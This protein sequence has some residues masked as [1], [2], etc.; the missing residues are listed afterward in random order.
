ML[1]NFITKHKFNLSSLVLILPFV[2]FY[3][4]LTP[5]FP[6]MWDKRAVGQFEVTIMPY[7][8]DQP[9]SHHGV[10][11]KDFMLFFNQ[12]QVQTIRQ[13]Y[14]NIGS[15]AL[16]ISEFHKFHEGILHGSRHGKE[17]HALAPEEITKQDKLWLTIENWQGETFLT[18]WPIPESITQ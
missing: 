4:S 8:L 5:E 10:N 13:A 16:P 18:S 1:A 2:F 9:Y 14:V 6:P 12:D 7:N 3:Q 15:S 17:V 11:V